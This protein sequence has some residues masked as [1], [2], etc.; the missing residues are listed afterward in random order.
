MVTTL[1]P[2][3]LVNL[4]VLKP[5]LI[6]LIGLQ[7]SACVKDTK[8][9]PEPEPDTVA[10]SLVVSFKATA[11]NQLLVPTSGNYTNTSGDAFTVTK[12]NYMISNVVLT[13][14]DGK[15]FVEPESYHLI[16]HVGGTTS[17][18]ITNLPTGTYSKIAFVLGVD[19]IRNISGAQT[20]ALDTGNDMYW[21]WNT[22]Y[23][24]FKLEGEYTSNNIPE[25]SGYTIHIGGFAGP[26][27][28]LQNSS[29]N[30]PQPIVAQAN[31]QSK[32]YCV[33]S[34]DEIFI[35][36]KTL[37]FDYYYDNVNE[38]TFQEIS[39]NYKDMISVEKVEN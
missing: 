18:T 24:F 1:F 36:P 13:T 4:V 12:F 16:K 22:G 7:L 8:I 10:P 38:K 9:E 20:G 26:Y 15:T 32:L 35:K 2:D 19:S 11:N 28:C 21:D 37:G 3:F 14:T 23:I 25:K 33:T 31:K 34:V 39:I 30:L 17:F 5:L 29:L 6:I 27:K